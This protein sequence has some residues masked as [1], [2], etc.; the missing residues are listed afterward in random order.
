[1]DRRD[2]LAKTGAGTGVV[3]TGS[4]G[5]G[6]VSGATASSADGPNVV[7]TV[8]A[9]GTRGFIAVQSDNSDAEKQIPLSDG[10]NEQVTVLGT[11]VTVQGTVQLSG[12]VY[13]DGTWQMTSVS[14]PTYVVGEDDWSMNIV[15]TEHTE[16]GTFDPE[17]GVVTAPL[18]L[19]IKL[20]GALEQS[21][22]P[23]P[24]GLT[25]TS[26][27]SGNMVGRLNR[28]GN[29]VLAVTLVNNEFGKITLSQN[30]AGLAEYRP[31]GLGAPGSNW[32]ELGLE[33]TVE[34]PSVLEELDV[35]PPA[36]AGTNPPQ[37]LD[38]DGLYENVR[39]DGEFDIA[40]VQALFDNLDSDAV[41]KHADRYNF[42][43]NDPTEVTILDVQALF[44]LLSE[45]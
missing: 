37:D 43:G 31:F 39:G 42:S 38:G 23:D 33:M 10:E 26:G 21:I 44:N 40:D 9:T 27:T 24:F 2:F 36:V 1:M 18:T 8:E 11:Q 16:P 6:G 20:D 41:Q 32:F 17:S 14:F 45:S 25:L 5:V 34:D 30:G 12:E 19:D 35:G 3:V 22:F 7:T 13:N 29:S 15:A 28:P 4:A